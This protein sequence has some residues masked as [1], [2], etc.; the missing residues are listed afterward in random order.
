[1]YMYRETEVIVIASNE[2]GDILTMTVITGKRKD[3]RP[4][5]TRLGVPLSLR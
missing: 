1:M 5:V 2:E 3:W 4:G